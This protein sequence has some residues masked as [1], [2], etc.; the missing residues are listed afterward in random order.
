[1]RTALPNNRGTALRRLRRY[2]EAVAVFQHALALVPDKAD[3]R[4]NLAAAYMDWAG[5]AGAS[6]EQRRVRLR[7]AQEEIARALRDAPNLSDGVRLRELI[8]ARL[9]E[10]EGR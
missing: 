7:H 9:R 2:A 8:A 3:I 10:V 5:E 6:Q 4:F 1:L